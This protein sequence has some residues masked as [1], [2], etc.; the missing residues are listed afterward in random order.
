[1]GSS[2]RAN[3]IDGLS[4][5][6]AVRH[7]GRAAR[8]PRL[9]QSRSTLPALDGRAPA[10][11]D[12][13]ALRGRIGRTVIPPSQEV[14]CYECGY[15]HKVTGRMHNTICPR[16]HKTLDNSD[17]AISG[18]FSHNLR[19][20]GNIE[21]GP[22]ASLSNASLTARDIIVA[23]SAG[24]S[25]LQACRCLELRSGASVDLS[26]VE[27]RDLKISAG[28]RFSFTG[29]ITCHNLYVC[30]E[31]RANVHAAGTVRIEQGGC[32]RGRLHG[33][34]LI[35]EE[36]GGLKARLKILPAEPPAAGKPVDD[37]ML[38]SGRRTTKRRPREREGQP[39]KRKTDGD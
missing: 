21:I 14:F 30:G 4:S 12:E 32:L 36:V 18:K 35:V 34:S 29:E 8:D 19:T 20:I 13:P 31:L 26:L 7:S 25:R 16:C 28:G 3:M 17:H 5:V 10:K 38:K 6:R 1:M 9:R 22:D 33:A 2:K 15:R 39:A 37:S 24:D 27:A 11:P 23:G